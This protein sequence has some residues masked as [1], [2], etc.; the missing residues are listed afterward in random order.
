GRVA[1]ERSAS[2]GACLVEADG[3]GAVL[4]RPGI[5]HHLSSELEQP[6]MTS[7]CRR[8]F[9]ARAAAATLGAASFARAGNSPNDKVAGPIMGLRGRGKSLASLFAGLKDVR[10]AA[11]C[12]IADRLVPAVARGL[13]DQGQAAPRVEKDVR[14]LLDDK[15]IGALVIAAPNHWHAPA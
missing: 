8:R 15:K 12:E 2:I 10:V 3:H 14:R 7:L 4:L 9:L 13:Q 6:L 1:R 11:L 5:G